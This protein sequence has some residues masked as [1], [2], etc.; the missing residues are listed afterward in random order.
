MPADLGVPNFIARK[1]ERAIRDTVQFG[2]G[3]QLVKSTDEYRP[4]WSYG[5]RMARFLD[6]HGNVALGAQ[7]RTIAPED[8]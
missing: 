8:T 3:A 7:G 4:V 1:L 6:T 2:A 5:R